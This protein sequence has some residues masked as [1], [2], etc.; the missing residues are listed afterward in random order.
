MSSFLIAEDKGIKTWRLQGSTDWPMWKQE[1]EM[2]LEYL[3]LWSVVNIE[4]EEID[5][6]KTKLTG[7][8]KKDKKARAIIWTSISKEIQPIFLG[9]TD[10]SARIWNRLKKEFDRQSATTRFRLEE[11]LDNLHLL[12]CNG[13]ADYS[14][15][16]QGLVKQIGM[17]GEPLSQATQIRIFLKNAG[18]AYETWVKLKKISARETLPELE[19]LA[20][21]LVDEA[22]DH[23]DFENQAR[24]TS[25]KKPWKERQQTNDGDQKR[26]CF[27]CGKPGHF[28][29]E[30]EDFLDEVRQQIKNE[31]TGESS[32]RSSGNRALSV[33]HQPEKTIIW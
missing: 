9:K 13:V 28:I 21:D 18:P 8:D 32:T 31:K 6:K 16:F 4:N 14:H 20:N 1:M 19:D 11:E 24:F 26:K 29:K 30:C 3:D 2:I 23:K 10:T 5:D 33:S 7:F 27:H 22:T 12:S 25:H 15:R 17:T